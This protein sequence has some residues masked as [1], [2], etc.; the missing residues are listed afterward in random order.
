[1]GKYTIRFCSPYIAAEASLS[2]PTFL[3]KRTIQF[4]VVIPM[5]EYRVFRWERKMNDF[6]ATRISS[7]QDAP[8]RL[9]EVNRPL[10]PVLS[11]RLRSEKRATTT[12]DKIQ[13]DD[14]KHE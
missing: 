8:L 3:A 9:Y 11:G 13:L 2:V 4:H 14:G 10:A 1:M 12:D 5:V 6:K 7:R